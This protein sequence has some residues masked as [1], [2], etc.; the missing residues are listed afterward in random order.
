[1]VYHK[2]RMLECPLRKRAHAAVTLRSQRTFI[3]MYSV[4]NLP[5]AT[6]SVFTMKQV[7]TCRCMHLHLDSVMQWGRLPKH[8]F[9]MYPLLSL[10][11]LTDLSLPGPAASLVNYLEIFYFMTLFSCS[12]LEEVCCCSLRILHI[13][14]VL[15][16]VPVFAS[17]IRTHALCYCRL[18]FLMTR[19]LSAPPWSAWSSPSATWGILSS[20]SYFFEF[21][22]HCASKPRV[23]VEATVLV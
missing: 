8:F 5:P 13:L 18:G 6:Y 23:E 17:S 20:D 4:H 7:N 14:H 3:W 11:A 1:M 9:R 15:V 10:S 16:Q 21:R 12:L 2:G 19:I 22:Q